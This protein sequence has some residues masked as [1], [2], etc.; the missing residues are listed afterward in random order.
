MFKHIILI[1][2][3]WPCL[4]FAQDHLNIN[5]ATVSDGHS[6][7]NS[8]IKEELI[9][10]L[11][12][13][14]GNEFRF[15]FPKKLQHTGDWSLTRAK[16][17]LESLSK[18]SEVDIVVAL[19]ILGSNAV[20][21]WQP[22]KPVFAT[23]VINAKAQGFPLTKNGTS[24]V[25]NLHYL[26]A[27]IELISK[28]KQFQIA[29]Q[30][31]HIGILTDNKIFSALP[32]LA[33][34]LKDSISN[35]SFKVSPIRYNIENPNSLVSQLGQ[36]DA[37]FVM[38]Q[39][40]MTKEQTTT[41]INLINSHQIPSFSTTG[42]KTVEAGMLMGTTLVPEINHLA[43]QIAIDIRDSFLGRAFSD[44]P[45][46]IDIKDRLIVNLD[47]AKKIR[48]DIPFEIL[49]EADL[50]NESV[51]TGRILSLSS[52]VEE[53]LT[54]NLDY[55]I[56]LE[57][58]RS[59]RQSTRISRASLLPQLS[60][61]LDFDAKDRDLVG[62]GATRTSS[63]GL[64]LGQSLYSESKNSQYDISKYTEK[65]QE[66]SLETTRLDVIEQTAKAY[67][68]VLMAKSELDIQRDNLKLTRSNLE[69]AEYRYK[70]GATDRSEVHRFETELGSSLQSVSNAQS[71]HKTSK[72]TL[73]QILHRPIEE[74]FQIKEP[75]L[76]QPQIFGDKRLEKFIAS[77]KNVTIF[78]NFLSKISIEDSPELKNLDA[79]IKAQERTLL[80]A[81]RKRYV[82][83]VD[84]VARV[85]RILD[86]HGAQFNTQHDENWS[87]GVQFSLPLYQGSRI[88]AEKSQA[89]I[90]LRRLDLLRKQ[91]KD[92]IEVTT[93]NSVAQAG[94][95]RRN[96]K[97]ANSA[98]E[99]AK[100]TLT[101][102][103]DSY[104]RG[105]ASY[106]D[107]LDAQNS[108]LVSRLS[109]ANTKYQHILDL[110]T[111]QR[112]IGF[113]DFSVAKSQKE[114]WFNSFYK[115]V[116]TYGK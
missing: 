84:L 7:W 46:A 25:K 5:V 11:K 100:N 14:E 85:D 61:G 47:T 66:S 8:K 12:V 116:Q 43:R 13:L 93:R 48:L 70:V 60:A 45:V 64:S 51:L 72:N 49:N 80:A 87:I 1:S 28:L 104:V 19:D 41:L 30:A 76:E 31:E 29:T 115:Y 98:V 34:N 90:E 96:I 62:T 74:S 55:A 36:V 44:L 57:D 65:S 86:D 102:V 89:N 27:N 112:A 101:L 79:K 111:L 83:D 109:S 56:A 38:P 9:K 24:G 52:V 16:K 17:S 67:L 105:S 95:S 114:S 53:S 73:N 42:S 23:T 69:R 110:I 33:K 113:F 97:Y 26:T 40:R 103:T 32:F 2:I 59:S 37:L 77:P 106:T 81:S 75:S 91:T 94:T 15:N 108:Y 71:L 88:S 20:A 4:S 63:F 82:P 58:M 39:L 10:E 18:N 6:E 21:Q 99:A 35:L 78:K 50:L 107:L 22:N 68:N 54:Q 3:L 92:F